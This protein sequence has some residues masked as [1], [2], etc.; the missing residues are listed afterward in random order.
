LRVFTPFWRRVQSLRRPALA[1][2]EEV[3][4]PRRS[5]RATRSKAGNSSRRARIGPAVL[6]E[7]WTPGEAAAQNR[8][9]ASLEDVA[10]YP[11]SAIG[12]P[13]RHVATITTSALRRDQPR[14]GLGTPRDLRRPSILGSPPT[15][16]SS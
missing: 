8:L 11:V 2:A 1:A 4:W 9:K 13:Q 12:R 16:T 7:N 5:S 6:R 10:G 3:F 14:Q 15:S